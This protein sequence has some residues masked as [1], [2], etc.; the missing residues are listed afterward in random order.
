MDQSSIPQVSLSP[1][2]RFAQ[3]GQKLEAESLFISPY[4]APSFQF[5]YNPDSLV[6]GN[7]YSIYDE[8]HDDDQV[9]VAMSLKKDMVLNTGWTIRCDNKEIQKAITDNLENIGLGNGLESGFE[10]SL[11]DILSAYGYGFNLSEPLYRSPN[12]S[13][14]GKWELKTIKVRPPHSFTFEINDKGD[15]IQIKQ[16]A[17]RGILVFSPNDFMHHVYQPEFGNPYGKSDLKA[18]HPAW[19]AKK[20]IYRMSMR[21]AERFAGALTIGRYSP[22]MSP[23]DISRLHTVIQSIQ[24][25]TSLTI[26]EEAKIELLQVTKDSSDVYERMLN[27]LNMWIARAILIPDL[28]GVSGEKTSG[29][30]LSL[31]K[32]HFKIFLNSI[33]NDRISLQK[34]ITLRVIKPLVEANYGNYPCFFEF[35]PMEIGEQNELL[36]MWIDAV[37]G[38]MFKPTEDEI[39]HLRSKT[40]FPE[41]PVEFNADPVQ[42]DPEGNPI[43][44]RNPFGKKTGNPG[45]EKKPANPG[46]KEEKD[47]AFRPKSNFEHK[48]DFASIEKTLEK[49][50]N[51]LSKEL[52]ALVK[53]QARDIIEQV[54]SKGIIEKFRPERLQELT[55]RYQRD[56]N[57]LI[58]GHFIRLF[59]SGVEFARHEVYGNL[60]KFSDADIFP[61]EFEDI[62]RA[63]SFKL[64]GDISQDVLK[65]AGNIILDGIKSGAGQ[66]EI[67]RRIMEQIGEYEERHI[68][69]IV[70]TKTTEVFN[71][72]RKTFFDTD[73]TAKEIITGYQ[74]SAVM[75]DRTSAVCAELDGRSYDKSD[76]DY[77][78]RITPPLHFNCRSLLV[79]VTRFESQEDFEIPLSIDRLKNLGGNLMF[80]K[81]SAPGAGVGGSGFAAVQGG[82]SQENTINNNTPNTLVSKESE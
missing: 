15:V 50:D 62:I 23:S 66:G 79:P 52:L 35:K 22:S 39:N 9:K 25:N 71:A 13:T 59:K 37:N 78:A 67:T 6:R 51:S 19:K 24:D 32:E 74:F 76:E 5:P 58:K 26:P 72:S 18:A 65:R 40:G 60:N 1:D 55:P 54:R 7:N 44:Q 28:M 14:S 61:D 73:E 68:Q 33:Q 12:E 31:G 75:D 48:M 4:Y 43:D 36:R 45:K 81:I 70:R 10:E 16:F 8:M 69:T 20:F 34:K 53:D 27:M 77:L 38:R 29:G 64:T 11:R 3:A 49:S 41:G 80:K 46:K 17:N 42:F 63:D 30:S 56:M 57:D 2:Y 82:V 47:Y 21:Y